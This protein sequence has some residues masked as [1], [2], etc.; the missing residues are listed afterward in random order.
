MQEA[1]V[2][3]GQEGQGDLIYKKFEGFMVSLGKH[4]MAQF[5]LEA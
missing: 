2:T 5:I 4:E 3:Y 1:A